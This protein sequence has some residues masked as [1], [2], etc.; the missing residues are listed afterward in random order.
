MQIY[1]QVAFFSLIQ[2]IIIKGITESGD[3]QAT[4]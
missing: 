2:L 3:G 4:N 1:K